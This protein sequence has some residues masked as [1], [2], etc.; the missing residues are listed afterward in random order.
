M[1]SFDRLNAVG[2]RA[3]TSVPAAC[4]S[5]WLGAKDQEAVVT[6]QVCEQ[7]KQVRGASFGCHPA[8]TLRKRDKPCLTPG[9]QRI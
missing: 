9:W 4:G 8:D 3:A 6:V 1:L 2:Y 5:C 7:E